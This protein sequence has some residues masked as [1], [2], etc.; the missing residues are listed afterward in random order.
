MDDDPTRRE[1]EEEMDNG[2]PDPDDLDPNRMFLRPISEDHVG[3]LRWIHARPE[4]V[5]WWDEPSVDFPWD[6]PEST[7]LTILVDGQIG[8]MIQY[9]EED[10]PKYRHAGID[11]FI[12][13][14]LQNKGIGTRA[15]RE[16]AKYLFEARGHHRLEIDPA[17]EN[18]AAIRVYEK[19]G[20]QPVGLTRRSERDSDGRGWH[21]G[22]LMDMLSTEFNPGEED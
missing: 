13:P 10:D 17:V 6:E 2:R 21:D 14:A 4:V 16:V 3:D 8:G 18:L 1:G 11:L 20:F 22:L 15:V 5:R 7:R 9:W 19:V 12:D